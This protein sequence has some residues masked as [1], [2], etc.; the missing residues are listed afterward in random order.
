MFLAFNKAKA[1]DG[2]IEFINIYFMHIFISYAKFT[3]EKDFALIWLSNNVLALLFGILK[4][5]S[6]RALL[7]THIYI[8]IFS[9][10]LHY[11][12]GYMKNSSS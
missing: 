4:C 8:Y 1:V 12:A 6:F 10:V 3:D 2:C 7:S 5:Q 11:V 9:R